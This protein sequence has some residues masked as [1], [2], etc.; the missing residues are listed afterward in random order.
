MSKEERYNS[1][2]DSDDLDRFEEEEDLHR[3]ESK[4]VE[5]D[6]DHKGEKAEQ[7]DDNEMVER[8]QAYFFED[9]TLARHF[10]NFIDDH[11]HV[12]DLSSDEYK[13]QYTNVFEEYKALFESRME[14]FIQEDLRCSIQDVYNALKRKVDEDENSNEAFF[15]QVLIAVTDFDVFMTMMRE[16][17]RKLQIQH[18]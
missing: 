10:E 15:A 1:A 13:L 2:K 17:A 12:V 5:R 7:L 3:A 14:G 6:L 18:K 16:S 4:S 8:M 9:E 11:S